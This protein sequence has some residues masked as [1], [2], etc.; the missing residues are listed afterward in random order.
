MLA[1][2]GHAGK[3]IDWDEEGGWSGIKLEDTTTR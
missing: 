3:P 1:V 2:T